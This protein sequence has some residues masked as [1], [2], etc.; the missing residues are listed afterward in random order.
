MPLSLVCGKRDYMDAIDG[1]NWR[2]GDESHPEKETIFFGGTYVKHPLALASAKAGLEQLR[3]H[4][5][6]IY[7]HL[8]ELMM[9]LATEV[10]RF[11][12]EPLSDPVETYPKGWPFLF[13]KAGFYLQKLTGFT[14]Y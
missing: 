8:S 2:Y 3:D 9:L 12:E 14:T 10:N 11:F 13:K 7:R 4:G 1:G 6:E 5:D